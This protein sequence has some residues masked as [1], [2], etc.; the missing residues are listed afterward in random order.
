M[1][2][3]CVLS[4]GN[5]LYFPNPS[6]TFTT[7]FGVGVINLNLKTHICLENIVSQHCKSFVFLIT[8][9]E[10]GDLTLYQSY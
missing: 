2:N 1:Y 8:R 5:F 4:K 10:H 9:Y 3:C 6:Y 7:I